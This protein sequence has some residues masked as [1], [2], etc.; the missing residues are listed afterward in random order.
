ML[1]LASDPG[2]SQSERNGAESTKLHYGSANGTAP[3]DVHMADLKKSS[4]F[5]QGLVFLEQQWY[6]KGFHFLCHKV[7]MLILLKPQS[8]LGRL[9]YTQQL[10]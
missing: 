4:A 1:L 2:R 5:D 3:G 9:D 6:R 8:F 10:R 7:P